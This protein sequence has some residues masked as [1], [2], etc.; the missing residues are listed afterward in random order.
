MVSLMLTPG[1]TS[2]L[3]AAVPCKP[4]AAPNRPHCQAQWLK[5]QHRRQR[6]LPLSSQH[7]HLGFKTSDRGKVQNPW[8]RSGA[9]E[10]QMTRGKNITTRIATYHRPAANARAPY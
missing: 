6:V 3:R 8:K 7:A 1:T 2:P 5:A 10:N 9:S 4:V